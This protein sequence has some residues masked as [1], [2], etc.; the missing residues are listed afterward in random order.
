MSR[1][2]VLLVGSSFSSMPLLV[3]IKKYDCD[4][5]VC[6]ALKDDPAHLYADGSFYVD[7]SSKEALLE[8]VLKENFT[9]IVPSCNDFSYMS[10]AWVA[11][12]IGFP[13][14]DKYGVSMLLHS[15][16]LFRKFTMAHN[17]S[18]PRAVAISPTD[19]I[20]L[21]NLKF[22]LLIKPV[23]S[24]SGKGMTKVDN[25]I[26]LKNAVDIARNNSLSKTVVAEEFIE[27]TLHSHSAFVKKCKIIGDFFVDEYCTVYQYQVNNSSLSTV[28]TETIK[29]K[30]RTCI[31]KVVSTLMLAD[32]LLHTQFIVTGD[33]FWLV[34]PMRRCPGDLYGKL[35]EFSTGA[36]YHDLYVRSFLEEP[37]PDNIAFSVNNIKY[38]SRHTISTKKSFGLTSFEQKI[39]S[40]KSCF[41]PLKNSGQFLKAAPYDKVGIIFSEFDNKDDLS[42]NTPIL[43]KFIDVQNY[44]EVKDA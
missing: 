10:S 19:E 6:G 1:K 33:S 36:D 3:A 7:Y 29:E 30:V 20:D 37:M 12:K 2:K 18:V 15:K 24:S 5:F 26:Y 28:L 22:P 4:L 42:R 14:F 39:P 31:S 35:I 44:G 25:E 23:D 27:G 34:E 40:K 13:G 9:N 17:L 32:G 11:S 16:D 41:Y 38:F 21:R 43:E 8:L